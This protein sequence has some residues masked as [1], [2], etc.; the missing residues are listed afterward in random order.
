MKCRETYRF[1]CENLDENLASARC[2]AI[3]NHI[4]C[5]PNCQDYLNSVKAT[6]LLYRAA[7]GP[8]LSRSIHRELM[9]ALHS[10]MSR[11]PKPAASAARRNR[12]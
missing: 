6:I 2:R 12:R 5:C 8:K 3:R 1:I 7:P 11:V 4:A 10:E 9:K